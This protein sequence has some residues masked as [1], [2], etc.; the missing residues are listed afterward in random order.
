MFLIQNRAYF[1]LNSFNRHCPVFLFLSLRWK[2][3]YSS[4]EPAGSVLFRTV[5]S[6][7][8]GSS[9]IRFCSGSACWLSGLTRAEQTVQTDQ[10]RATKGWRLPLRQGCE[11]IKIEM[12][13]LPGWLKTIVS[14]AESFTRFLW[15]PYSRC[16][17]SFFL[18]FQIVY[19]LWF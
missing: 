12:P 2:P 13:T 19:A 9:K 16:I 5:I 4:A 18:H 15:F 10:E 17:F 8:P 6:F 14:D 11:T 1:L 7:A 3:A